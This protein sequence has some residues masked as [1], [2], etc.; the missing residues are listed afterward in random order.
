MPFAVCDVHLLPLCSFEWLSA[1]LHIKDVGM[2]VLFAEGRIEEFIEAQSVSAELMATPEVA[3]GIAAAMAHFHFSMLKHFT[4]LDHL[5][6]CMSPV[7]QIWDRLRD[8]AR[9]GNELYKPEEL[10]QHGLG[11]IRQEVGLFTCSCSSVMYKHS[12]FCSENPAHSFAVGQQSLSSR[13]AS[14]GFRNVLVCC[15]S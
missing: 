14:L 2:Q 15:C 8:W 9:I 4:M 5:P 6:S 12:P 13:K 7:A 1:D 3:V 11:H 10:K